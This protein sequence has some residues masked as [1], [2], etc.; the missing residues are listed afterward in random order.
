MCK[1]KQKKIQTRKRHT[2]KTY[3][4]D[5]PLPQPFA[6]QNSA[7]STEK[8]R[9]ETQHSGCLHLLS[10]LLPA[11]T[12]DEWRRS[13]KAIFPIIRIMFLCIFAESLRSWYILCSSWRPPWAS[14]LSQWEETWH[15]ITNTTISRCSAKYSLWCFEYRK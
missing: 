6:F 10:F 5:T 8:S 3:I 15:H 2:H 11:R 7:E 12:M 13:S 9:I 14:I 4:E 1:N